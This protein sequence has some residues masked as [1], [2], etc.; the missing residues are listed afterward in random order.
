MFKIDLHVLEYMH[1]IYIHNTSIYTFK[2]KLPSLS[3]VAYSKIEHQG[4]NN[5]EMSKRKCS[6][7]VAFLKKCKKKTVERICFIHHIN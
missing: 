2:D 3:V 4:E 7:K 5:K 1:S 6:Q